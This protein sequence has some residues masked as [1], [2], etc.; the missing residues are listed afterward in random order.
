MCL[1]GSHYGLS[2]PVKKESSGV[3]VLKTVLLEQGQWECFPP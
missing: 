3:R 2:V 1:T